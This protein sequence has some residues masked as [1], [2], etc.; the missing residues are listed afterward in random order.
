MR[1]LYFPKKD[2]AMSNPQAV[3]MSEEEQLR[4]CKSIEDLEERAAEMARDS[5]E[6]SKSVPIK[7]VTEL[8]LDT[9]K[10]TVELF[11]AKIARG[12]SLLEE[13][14]EIYELCKS[15]L[16]K[17]PDDNAI[18][19]FCLTVQERKVKPLGSVFGF[20][21][22]IVE[23]VRSC[24]EQVKDWFNLNSEKEKADR[25]IVNAARDILPTYGNAII[26][27]FRELAFIWAFEPYRSLYKLSK[28]QKECAEKYQKNDKDVNKQMASDMLD[29][30][31]Y[32][33]VGHSDSKPG[34]YTKLSASEIPKSIRVLYDEK[35]GLLSGSRGL[36]AWLGKKD[37][38]IVVS[39]S[40]T[41][42][43]NFE[44]VYADICQL[45]Q[46]SVLYLKAAGLLKILLDN[47]PGKK[48]YV[49]GHSLGGGL[50]QFA[51]TANMHQNSGRLTGYGYNP[52]GLS[53]YSLDYLEEARLKKS[54]DNMWIFKTCKDPVSHYGGLLGCITTLPQTD[55]NGHDIEDVK[56]CMKKYLTSPK[57]QQLSNRTFTWRYHSDS[58]FIP[59]TK[60]LSLCSDIGT[61]YPI[62]NNNMDSPATSLIPFEVPEKLFGLLNISLTESN[63]C[64]GVYNKLNGTAHT[65][66]NRMLLLDPNCPIVTNN[67][68]GNIH[69]SII[70]GKFGLGINEFIDTLNQVYADSGEAFSGSQGNFQKLLSNLYDPIEYDK[71]AWCC[72]IML[73]FGI[74]MSSLFSQWILAEKYFDIFL[75]NITSDRMDL[76]NSIS[77]GK[78]PNETMVKE[79]LS[80]Y[81]DIVVK[82]AEVLLNEAVRWGV[83]TKEKTDKYMNGIKSFADSVISNV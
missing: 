5:A 78:E 39:Y 33:Y 22:S 82:H 63:T 12:E 56:K 1:R 27:V 18:E 40:G 15:E 44:M 3:Q 55:K 17:Y 76:Y 77:S 14:K 6:D 64:M 45:S 52:A 21:F 46:P 23:L 54:A 67:S 24:I 61:K 68:I 60:T 62:F 57:P 7:D 30:A 59:Y 29:I 48:F 31:Q 65:V 51:L 83:F 9:Y 32:G 20:I 19:S 11:D 66:M 80:G 49:T 13:E 47:F 81:K 53:S 8:T 38:N 71:D 36:L 75:N 35:K 69:S 2:T 50:T 26:G 37:N 41:D 73:Q 25:A 79:F 58:D 4:F 42:F 72:G 74:D 70:Y 43:K 34:E 28:A 10:L 16:E